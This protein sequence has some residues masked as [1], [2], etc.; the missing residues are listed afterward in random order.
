MGVRYN[1][2]IVTD[3]LVLALDAANVKSYPGSGTIWTDMSGLGNHGT[4]VNGPTFSSNNAGSMVFDGTND[5]VNVPSNAA[6]AFGTGGFTIEAWVYATGTVNGSA[7]YEGATSGV[8][9]D[10]NGG[11]LAVAHSYVSFLL[12][13]PAAFLLN[14]WTHVAVSRIGTNLTLSKNLQIVASSSSSNTNFI[15]SSLNYIGYTGSTFFP[16]YIPNIKMYNRGLSTAEI[17]QNFNALRG[18]YGI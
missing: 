12:T 8:G 14:A 15:Q 17:S 6:F 9:L 5:Y 3:G 4:L 10:F 2:K 16:G 11:S 7:I 13:D 1:P 18:R